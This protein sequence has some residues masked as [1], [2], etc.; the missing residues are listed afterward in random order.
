SGYY[1]AR[2]N[3]AVYTFGAVTYRGGANEPG[4]FRGMAGGTSTS[5]G[6]FLLKKDGALYTCGD[7]GYH[8]GANY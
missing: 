7:A 2:S 6:Y 1:L 3:G 5:N 8:G 4:S